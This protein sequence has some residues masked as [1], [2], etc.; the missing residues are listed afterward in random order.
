MFLCLRWIFPLVQGGKT[1]KNEKQEERLRALQIGDKG[2]S[3]SE[4]LA[5]LARLSRQSLADGEIVMAIGQIEGCIRLVHGMR[6][7]KEKRR[8][9]DACAV[10]DHWRLG[11][12]HAVIGPTHHGKALG[13]LRVVRRYY[14]W[15]QRKR[16]MDLG[17]AQGATLCRALAAMARIY[18]EQRHHIRALRCADEGLDVLYLNEDA[19]RSSAA[20]L[21][22]ML[23]FSAR[24]D[25]L[26]GLGHCGEVVV[27][28]YE[29]VLLHYRRLVS[30]ASV[31][32]DRKRL[33]RASKGCWPWAN[34]RLYPG[35]TMD[36]AAASLREMRGHLSGPMRALA[37]A[38]LKE[39][40]V[41]RDKG[42]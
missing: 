27:R 18:N 3:V 15:M 4:Q 12:C 24:G 35:K 39:H 36:R 26:G 41:W 14:K 2:G 13:H 38:I 17:V 25:A 32:A 28:H 40:G 16:R 5:Y 37:D 1:L 30:S 10:G 29:Q 21:I 19:L 9:I 6:N 11:C 7:S 42:A 22:Q 31:L 34:D 23:C 33:L 8:L 20:D